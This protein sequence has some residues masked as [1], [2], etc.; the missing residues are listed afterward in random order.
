MNPEPAPKPTLPALPPP[1]SGTGRFAPVSDAMVM[2][3]DDEP[4]MTD[5]IQA[6][7]EEA[8]YP[9]FLGSNDP[10]QALETIRRERPRKPLARFC[11]DFGP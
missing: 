5:V 9:R 7:L 4:M 6:Y 2:M 11:A 10:T 3:V 1:D 8:G